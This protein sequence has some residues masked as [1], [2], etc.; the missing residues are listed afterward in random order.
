MSDKRE[1]RIAVPLNYIWAVLA[2]G[3]I[4]WAT[5]GTF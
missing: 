1:I 4:L 5:W 2:F 3:I